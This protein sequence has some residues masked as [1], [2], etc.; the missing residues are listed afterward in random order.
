MS[1]QQ[2]A[3]EVEEILRRIRQHLGDNA[4]AQTIIEV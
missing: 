4:A 2:L 3:A 1:L